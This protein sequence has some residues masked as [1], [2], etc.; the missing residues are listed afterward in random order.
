M[1]RCSRDARGVAAVEFAFI[2]PVML[3][4]FI[5]IIEFS[6]G[7]SVNRKITLAA[8]TMSDLTS[9]SQM[10]TT[11]DLSNFRTIVDAILTP[12]SAT[13]VK[14]SVVMLYI[15]PKTEKARAQWSNG[16][17]VVADG[18]VVQIPPSLVGRDSSG[19]VLP[20]QYLIKGVVSYRYVPVV[21]LVMA[22][23]G[24]DLSQTAYTRPRQTPCVFLGAVGQSCPVK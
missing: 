16:P 19:K 21:G 9:R 8:Q 20:G 3:V 7:I 22:S 11:T 10:V 24:L 15:D 14:A 17:D 23:A 13:G 12:F 1:K 2:A 4:L 18:T 5:G 6:S